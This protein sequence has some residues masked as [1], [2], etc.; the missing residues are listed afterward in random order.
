MIYYVNYRV[1]G[2]EG[3]YRAGPYESFADAHLEAKDIE[4]YEGVY[5]VQVVSEDAV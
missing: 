3:G 5:F 4:G 1:T 2:F